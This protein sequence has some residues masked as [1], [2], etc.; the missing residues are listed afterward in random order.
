[1]VIRELKL[2]PEVHVFLFLLL[3]LLLLLREWAVILMCQWWCSQWGCL[4]LRN[5]V[6][7][8]KVCVRF[9]L[10]FGVVVA[11]ADE[12][13][14]VEAVESGFPLDFLTV[15]HRVHEQ[16][17]YERLFLLGQAQP[18]YHSTTPVSS[19]WVSTHLIP[20]LLPSPPPWPTAYS[21][22]PYTTRNTHT[23]FIPTLLTKTDDPGLNL[24]AY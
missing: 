6:I 18:P 8:E 3:S 14:A 19:K 23:A 13:L 20:P 11:V 10:D 5:T 22:W 2:R 21:H 17:L 1:M 9:G 4:S 16:F 15:I 12:D 7:S 24:F